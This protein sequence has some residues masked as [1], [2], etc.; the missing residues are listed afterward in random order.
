MNETLK[1][2]YRIGGMSVLPCA[3]ARTRT[4]MLFLVIRS[5]SLIGRFGLSVLLILGT[6]TNAHETIPG[7]ADV[8]V[9]GGT[10]GGVVAAVQAARMGKTVILVEPSRHVGGM[11][12]GGLGATD[13][14]VAEAVGG[15]CRDF[16]Q[17]VKIHYSHPSAWKFERAADYTS[18]R[19]DPTADVMFHFE[20]RV[21]EQILFDML[22]EAGV[23]VVL[24]ERLDLNQSVT[25]SGQRIDAFEC[26]SGKRFSASMFIDATY[27]GDL[28]AQAGVPFHVGREANSVYGESMNGVQTQRVPYNGHS[29]FRPVSPYVKPGDASSGLLFGIHAH[30]PGEEGSGDQRVQAYCFRLCLTEVPENRVPFSKPANYDPARYELLLR[31]LISDSSTDVF[32]D[33]PEPR[34][35]ES[36]ALGY[37]PYIVIM[38]N[39]KTDMNSKGAISSNLVGGNYDYPNGDY[40]TREAIW[41]AHQSW[42]QGL[43]WF[44]QNDPR[45]P[46][47]YRMPLQTWGLAKDEFVDN[48]H[49]PHQLYVREARRMIG[50]FVMTEHHCSGSSVVEDSVGLGCYAMDSHVTQRYVDSAG[51]VRNE[52]NIGGRVPAP[53]PI[54]YRAIIPRS[55][56]CENLLVPVCCS[57]SHVAYGSIRME[58][59]YMILG[60]SAATAACLAIDQ[61][62]SVQAVEYQQLRNQLL[63]DQQRLV[64]PLPAP[65]KT[66]ANDNAQPTPAEN[67]L[68]PIVDT[69]G[70]PRVLLIGDS[71]SMGYTLPTR[72]LLKGRVNLHR[73]P[74]NAGGTTLG[75]SKLDAWLGTSKWDV[76]H[77]NFGLHDAKL[78]PE[79]VRHAPPDAYEANLREL[80]A[81]LQST[82]ARLI[83]ADTPVPNGGNLAPNRRFGSIDQYN[84]IARRV[85]QENKIAIN[86]LPAAVNDRIGEL[87]KPN[88]VHFTDEGSKVL[89]KAVAAAIELS[90]LR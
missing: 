11:T 33:H 10:A 24:G 90:L 78:P 49:W 63:A 34:E 27:E 61:R 82:G 70:L 69:P 5:L 51:W 46:D 13:F 21:A 6:Y 72:E 65:V 37:R 83:W 41:K 71:V 30:P 76:I 80:V 88:D 85:M 28:M 22:N 17:R 55:E 62:T 36:P 31:Y 58:P 16:Y 23:K 81:R 57:A 67:S 12:S 77:F 2:M 29:F 8:V 9:Y 32:S 87:Q 73:V 54:S 60:Q 14:K 84:A 18:H 4:G 42:H 26:E 86:N 74:A 47:K 19:H 39:R 20:P 75:L 53:Y 79:G 52:G 64:W 7:K 56:H 68:T 44:V 40:S 89:A 45:V 43:L 15:L 48:E 38:P 3:E 66:P 59:V 1:K 35:I 25:K 50:D